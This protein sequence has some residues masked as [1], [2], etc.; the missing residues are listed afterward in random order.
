MSLMVRTTSGMDFH[1]LRLI[2]DR[3]SE[4]ALDYVADEC[5]NLPA[6]CRERYSAFRIEAWH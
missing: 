5:Q 6:I 2:D 4:I 3:L 1:L